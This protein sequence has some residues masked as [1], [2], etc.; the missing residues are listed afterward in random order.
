MMGRWFQRFTDGRISHIHVAS[1]NLRMICSP[2]RLPQSLYRSKLMTLLTCSSG[3][4][5]AKLRIGSPVAWF[6]LVLL[7]FV[8]CQGD[9]LPELYPTTGRVLVDGEPAYGALVTFHSDQSQPLGTPKPFAR[10][11]AEGHYELTTYSTADG[12]PAGVYQVTVIWPENP[13]ARGPS[14]D[15]LSGKYADASSTPLEVTI[16]E[17]TTQ[18]PDF[19]LERL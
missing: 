8:G 16:D 19:Q 15:R 1:E 2:S 17:G 3:D 7:A 5:L 14:P 13:E 10:A 12:I 4:R 11:D 6:P 18:L 9:D